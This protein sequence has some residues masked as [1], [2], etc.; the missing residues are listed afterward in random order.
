MFLVTGD[1]DGRGRGRGRGRS[2]I[3]F[4]GHFQ[5][6]MSFKISHWSQLS[7]AEKTGAVYAIGPHRLQPKFNYSSKKPT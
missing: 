6:G 2:T 4:T 7:I 5:G 1:L 3:F